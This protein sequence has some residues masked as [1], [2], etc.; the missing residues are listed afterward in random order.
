MRYRRTVLEPGASSLRR[1]HGKEFPG[2]SPRWFMP[3]RP[4]RRKSLR[5]YLP[6]TRV[7]TNLGEKCV[8]NAFH[9]E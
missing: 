7:G 3:L 4:G 2:T 1:S 6:P 5:E 9:Y 8:H